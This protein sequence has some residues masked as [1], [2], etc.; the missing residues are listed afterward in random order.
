MIKYFILFDYLTSGFP[1]EEK[2]KC[3][4]LLGVLKKSGAETEEHSYDLM[5]KLLKC[6]ITNIDEL[7]AALQKEQPFGRFQYKF[8]DADLKILHQAV[9]RKKDAYDEYLYKVYGWS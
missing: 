9:N 7:K 4:Y 5:N 8:T 2:T 3:R 6:C 1:L